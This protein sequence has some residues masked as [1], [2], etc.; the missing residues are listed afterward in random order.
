MLIFN[1]LK[2]ESIKSNL[3]LPT[4]PY[5]MKNI[6]TLFCILI[7][8][9]CTTQAQGIWGTKAI[10]STNYPTLKVAIDSINAL[11]VGSPGITFNISPGHYERSSI[12]VIGAS[13]GT[14]PIV[15]K[16][17][18]PGV[19]PIITAQN[20]AGA[21]D[22]VLR[23]QGRD[24]VTIEGITL[25]DTSANTNFMETGIAM[26]RNSGSNGCKNVTIRNC[27][28]QMR[29]DSVS[30]SFGIGSYAT[31]SSG[32]LITPIKP[33]PPMRTIFFLRNSGKAF[34]GFPAGPHARTSQ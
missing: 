14:Q 13:S 18:G 3:I 34:I 5:S 29:G 26:F 19:N 6:F 15:F 30:P 20:G 22:A 28:I 33:A 17:N 1:D 21:Y 11:G 2:Y 10:P 24:N 25:K 27:I 8:S 16:K 9:V 4:Y 32:T 12:S 7:L 23:I 31:N